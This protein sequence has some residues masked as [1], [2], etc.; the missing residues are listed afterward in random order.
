MSA[1]VSIERRLCSI[2]LNSR[3]LNFYDQ[4]IK[5]IN[6]EGGMCFACG[7]EV[8]FHTEVQLHCPS[9]EP[10]AASFFQFWRL[11]NFTKAQQ[12]DEECTGFFHFTRRHGNLN[13]VNGKDFHF[14]VPKDTRHLSTH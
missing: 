1:L 14:M 11:G 2:N 4:S 13:V 6:N 3:R 7:A 8:S 10:C 12:V 9:F 5:V